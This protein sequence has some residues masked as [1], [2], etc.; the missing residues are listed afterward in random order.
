[1]MQPRGYIALL[2]V[3]ALLALSLSLSVVVTYASIDQ[4][5]SSFAVMRGAQ[6]LALAEGCTDDALL[7]GWR[8][9]NYEGGDYQYLGGLCH[10]HVD[11]QDSIWEITSSGVVDTFER[12]VR[13]RID[14]SVNPPI[15]LN[16]LEL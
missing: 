2:T 14:R 7:Q 10:V 12:T 9:I 3:L 5:Q 15:L 1:M 13:V 6:T 11:K 16:W 8:D 4:L